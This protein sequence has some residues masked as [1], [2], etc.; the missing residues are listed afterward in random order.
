MFYPVRTDSTFECRDDH[1][2]DV[3][4]CVYTRLEF[5]ILLVW[6]AAGVVESMRFTKGIDD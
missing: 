4:H 1:D 6:T 5:G 3:V 2:D